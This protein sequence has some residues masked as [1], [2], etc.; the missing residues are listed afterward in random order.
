V[1]NATVGC[2]DGRDVDRVDSDAEGRFRLAPEA[3]GCKGVARHTQLGRSEAMELV[4][5]RDNVFHL[6]RGGGIQGVVVDDHGAPLTPYMLVIQSYSASSERKD[7]DFQKYVDDPAGVFSWDG[8]PAGKYVL[9][10]NIDGR[11]PTSTPSIEVAAEKTTKDV[12]IVVPSGGKLEGIVVDAQT[13]TPI[14][15]AGIGLYVTGP[16]GLLVRRPTT[17]GADGAFTMTGLPAGPF[18]LRIVGKGY[19]SKV[20]SDVTAGGGRQTFAL[21]REASN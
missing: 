13:Q 16:F 21:D 15:A 8:L 2:D 18:P 9:L 11:A 17:A 7:I 12:K 19:Q 5:G 6:S 14:A 4:S 3:A 20:F 10:A 1:A